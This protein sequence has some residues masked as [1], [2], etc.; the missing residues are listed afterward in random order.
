MLPAYD[1]NTSDTNKQLLTSEY[2]T[3]LGRARHARKKDGAREG[4]PSSK[5]SGGLL[6]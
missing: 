1:T 3:T 2:I 4:A 5:P 6:T